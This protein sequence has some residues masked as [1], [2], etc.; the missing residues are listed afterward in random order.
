MSSYASEYPAVEFDPAYKKFF[1]EFY[2]ISDTPDAH[3]RYVDQFTSDATLVMA[4]KRAKGSDEILGLRKGLWEKVASRAHRPLKIF[5]YGPNANEVML[6]GTVKY[7]LKAGGENVVE[8]AAYAHLVKIDGIVKMD[9][10]QV[11][12]DTGAQLQSK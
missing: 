8:W 7:E 3:P 10:Y 5:P 2:A 6:H 9:F 11:Y 12:L 4:S 1:E